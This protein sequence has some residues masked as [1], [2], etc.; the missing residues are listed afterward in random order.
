MVAT[1]DTL[2]ITPDCISIDISSVRL[3]EEQYF[4]LCA[5]NPDLRIELSA[6]GELT[7]MPP[8]GWES[9]Q[10][11]S[12]LNFQVKLWNRQQELGVVFDSSTGFILPD[13]AKP[14]PDVAWVQ[15][16]RLKAL[17]PDP[18]KFLPLA[19]DFVIELRSASDS[20]TKLQ[21]KMQMYQDNGVRLGWLLNPQQREVEIYRMGQA[22]EILISPVSLSGED[23]LEGFMLDLTPIW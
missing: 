5:A 7:I 8:T 3:S 13:G 4:E 10:R 6:T 17:N 16:L 15:K 2:D 14:S 22:R 12:E 9:G 19:P 21:Q 1:L 20:L 23:V 11:N 18:T